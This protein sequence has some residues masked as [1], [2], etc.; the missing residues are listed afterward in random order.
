MIWRDL[1]YFSS[2]EK[3]ALVVLSVLILFAIVLLARGSREPVHGKPEKT[4]GHTGGKNIPGVQPVLL[5]NDSLHSTVPVSHSVRKQIPESAV[6]SPARFKELSPSSRPVNQRQTSSSRFESV[7]APDKYAPG[8]VIELNGADSANL[9]KVPGIGEVFAG[10]IVKFRRLLGGFYHVGQLREVYGLTE[11][12]YMQLSSW[13]RVDSSR[14]RRL[15]INTLPS[16]SLIRHPYLNSIQVRE[17]LRMRS[18]KGRLAGWHDL[19]LLE[20]FGET[21][22]Q[23]LFP[24]ICF[25]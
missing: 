21:D 13:F 23:R 12:R 4:A 10:R 2:G 6:V 8:T 22:R 14:I 25:D 24:Y 11:E 15:T 16:D 18:R 3:K 20:E 17:I 1:L 9:R 7:P 5:V 19:A